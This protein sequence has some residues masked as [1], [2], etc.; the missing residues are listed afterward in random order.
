M[1]LTFEERA[2]LAWSSG[3]GSGYFPVASGTFG[4]LCAVPVVWAFSHLS[5]PFWL[6]T[7]LV[8]FAITVH[9]AGIA[10]RAL[11]VVD[12]KQIVADEFVGMLLAL[13]FVPVTWKVYLAGFVLFRIFDV[14]KPWPASYFDTK[15]KNGFG[16][17]MDDVVAG[18]FARAGLEA[19]LR[20]GWLA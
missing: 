3:L 20:T 6:L 17:T 16:V 7:T 14:T 1:A 11:G 18:L 13:A 9:A 2:S 5:W 15:V 12:A 10:G 19:L 4:S 8:F